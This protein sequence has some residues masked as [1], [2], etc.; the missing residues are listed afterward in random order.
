[1]KEGGL[2]QWGRAAL[3]R[4]RWLSGVENAAIVFSEKMEYAVFTG[5]I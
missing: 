3:W 5:L 1:M 4:N 2:F